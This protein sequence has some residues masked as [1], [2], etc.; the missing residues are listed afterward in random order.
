[1][2]EKYK[3]YI[4]WGVT[5]FCVVVASL[6]FFFFMF[7]MKSITNLFTEI[8]H[9]LA[10]IIYGLIIAYLL[11]PIQSFWERTLLKWL[12]KQNRIKQKKIEKLAKGLSIFVALCIGLAIVI[13][14]LGLVIPKLKDSIVGLIDSSSTYA[15]IIESWFNKTLNDYPEIMATVD[16]MVKSSTSYLEDWLKNDL[17]GQV[18]MVLGGLT[19]S[20]I[21]ILNTIL[22]LVI[23]I[24]VSIYV[25][26]SKQQ[27]IG[28]GKKILYAICKPDIA[29]SVLDILRHSNKIFGGFIS[30]KILD[31]LII[32]IICFIWLSIMKTPYTLLVSVIVGVT[33][34]IPFFG[35]YI[36]AIPSAFLILLAEPKQCIYFIVFILVLQQFDGNIL[37]PKILG[38]STGL[39]AFW[40]VFAILL[41]GGL[42]GFVG[43]IIGVPTFGVLYYLI[44]TGVEHRLKKKLLPVDT[45]DYANID[46][47]QLE[48]MKNQIKY[49]EEKA[50]KK[51]EKKPV[52]LKKQEKEEKK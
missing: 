9:I 20:V 25:L 43:M 8:R 2:K 35:P 12:K 44:K 41:G 4:I 34:I 29:N 52:V 49:R 17:L 13:A 6:V 24:V 14:L 7:R 21:Y 47:I 3:H 19:S 32:G 26:S 39:S 50:E 18:N 16:E 10:P 42:F 46:R 40:V 28:Q 36:G 37:G 30:G 1:M 5:I 22:N 27:F 15:K 23:G 31:S 51:T 11:M 33:N 38:D 45:K 48:D